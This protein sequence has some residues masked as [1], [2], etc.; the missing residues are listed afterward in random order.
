MHGLRSFARSIVS[1]TQ[2]HNRTVL[3]LRCA[4]LAHITAKRPAIES[5][6]F[7]SC[8]AGSLAQFFAV[9]PYQTHCLS[10]QGLP[11]RGLRLV[12]A[13]SHTARVG[14]FRAGASAGKKLAGAGR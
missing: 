9:P 14:R 11:A 8:R 10:D 7:V 3:W 4:G 5:T 6:D 12:R 2:P 1:L 13:S